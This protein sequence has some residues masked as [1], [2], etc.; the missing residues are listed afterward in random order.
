MDAMTD[1]RVREVV[2]MKSAQIGWTELLLNVIGFHIDREPAPILMLNPTI[3]MSQAVSKD[4]IT[5]LLSPTVLTSRT[6]PSLPVKGCISSKWSR[7]RFP[8]RQARTGVGSLRI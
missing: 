3:E 8:P 4:R 7:G 1:P 5:G 6:G 2:V